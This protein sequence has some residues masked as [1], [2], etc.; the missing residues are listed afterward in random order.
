MNIQVIKDQLKRAIDDHLEIEVLYK[1]DLLSRILR[2]Y[3]YGVYGD[4]EKLHSYQ[5]SGP[6]ESNSPEGW[7]NLELSE[8]RQIEITDRKFFPPDKGYNSNSDQYKEI[9]HQIDYTG[10][11]SKQKP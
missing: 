7:K 3:H 4:S 1:S 11:S 5:V 10:M 8:I 9:E 2:P 6:S